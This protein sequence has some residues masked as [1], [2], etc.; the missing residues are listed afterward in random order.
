MSEEE[1]II[2]EIERVL[3]SL[4]REQLRSVLRFVLK[5]L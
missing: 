4:N 1:R 3:R 2:A 5:K